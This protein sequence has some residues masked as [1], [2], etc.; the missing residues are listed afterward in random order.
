MVGELERHRAE[1]LH[2]LDGTRRSVHSY[3]LH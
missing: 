2:N 3:A 1:S